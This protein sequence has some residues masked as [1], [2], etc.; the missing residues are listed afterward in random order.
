V[1]TVLLL[2]C[3]A[4]VGV[5]ADVYAQQSVSETL[6]FLLTNRSIPTGD[7]AG[8]EQAAAAT[9][10]TISTF[11]LS[12]LG[13]QPVSSAATGF[14][15]EMDPALGGIPT[16]ATE[17]FGPFFTERA[18]TS[19]AGQISLGVAFQHASFTSIDGRR[20]G[21]GTL[22]A[23]ASRLVGDQQPFD[24]EALTLRLR[25][26]TATFSAT[27]GLTDRLEVSTAV[28]VVS[29]KMEGER[30][31]TYRGSAV[32]QATASASASGLGDVTW[33]AK[34]NVLRQDSTALAVIAEGRLPT[35]RT[36][37]LLGAGRHTFRPRLTGS[38]EANRVT[39]NADIGYLF[40]S[41]SRE[42]DYGVGVTAAPNSRVTIV[43]ELVGRRLTAAGKLSESTAP[44]PSLIGVETIRLTAVERATDRVVAIAGMKVNVAASWLIAANVSRFLTDAGLTADWIPAVTIEYSFGG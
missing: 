28:P 3:L 22:V 5:P 15:Y 36:E 4:L 32:V 2:A 40:G 6:S 31:D 27:A 14:T 13:S 38:V 41:F 16:R 34:Y 7:F 42:F 10:D 26:N 17:S 37:D 19:G 23:T 35:G 33:R 30:V 20:L 9:R 25:T 39:V 1:R 12:E 43:G 24:V 21:D 29:L 44:H 18:L 8:D 11:L